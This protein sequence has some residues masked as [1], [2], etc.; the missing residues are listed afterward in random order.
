MN[1]MNNMTNTTN[2]NNYTFTIIGQAG[3]GKSN[4]C[5]YFMQNLPYKMLKTTDIIELNIEFEYNNS[6]IRVT[7]EQ[8]L[9]TDGLILMFDLTTPSTLDYLQEYLKLKIPTILVG[10][11]SDL[12]NLKDDEPYWYHCK[13]LE[14][15]KNKKFNKYYDISTVSYYNIDKP[16]NALMELTE[17]FAS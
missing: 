1:N 12:L 5:K 14:F 8:S 16:F 4:F 13:V 11:K 7:D 9:K 6:R 17:L 15:L 2:V 3:V 10:N